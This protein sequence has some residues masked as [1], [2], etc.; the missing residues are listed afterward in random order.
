MKKILYI[1]PQDINKRYGGGLAT[2]AYYDAVTRLFPG[3]V[4]LVMPE[5]YCKEKADNVIPAPSRSIV[6]VFASGSIHRY[7]SFVASHLEK[8]SSEYEICIINGGIYAGDMMDMIHG[9]GLKI[10]VIHHNFE[11]EYQ[12]DN[13][14]LW[15]LRGHY[16]GLVVHFEKMAYRK[17]DLN[18]FLTNA[19]I[20]LFET[21]YGKR[22]DNY[23]LGVFEHADAL[24]PNLGDVQCS[25]TMAISGSM[26]SVQTVKGILDF[27]NRYFSLVKQACPDLCVR[28]A[29]R[30]PS[31]EVLLF[32]QEND[33]RIKVVPNPEN[34]DEAIKDCRIFLCP[35]NVGGGLKLRV[36]DGLRLGMPILVHEVSAR[37]YDA[38]FQYPYFAVYNDEDSFAE[39]LKR[40]SSLCVDV[41][42]KKSVQQSYLS[43]FGFAAGVER[44]EKAVS[45]LM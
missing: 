29:G 5:E 13:R 33:D 40:L 17:A 42:L 4:D 8:H 34:M 43:V 2:R 30:S 31:P 6:S 36:M 7:R 27:K 25:S 41:E 15:T 18:C 28:I 20:E 14:S 11:R 19:D 3:R 24:T 12:M 23:L 22:D 21:C 39:G 37:G 45:I 16:A 32:A 44:M 9:F 10:M 1:S 35:T 38:F 26:N